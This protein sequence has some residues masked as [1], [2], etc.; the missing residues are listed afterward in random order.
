MTSDNLK[1]SLGITYD[2]EVLLK[3]EILSDGRT[4][5]AWMTDIRYYPDINLRDL[6]YFPG[7]DLRELE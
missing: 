3:E 5:S 6:Y 7:P 1:T 2:L 4:L